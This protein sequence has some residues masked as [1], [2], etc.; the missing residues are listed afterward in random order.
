M[1]IDQIFEKTINDLKQEKRPLHPFSPEDHQ[2]LKAYW[3]EQL[4]QQ[5]L[6]EINKVLCLLEHSQTY[7]SECDELFI[8]SLKE[9]QDTQTLVFLLSASAKHIV[10]RSQR[11]GQRIAF[12]FIEALKELLSHQD[13]E[14]LEWVL[15][16]IDQLGNQALILRPEIIKQKP[17]LLSVF[18]KHKKNSRMIIEMLEKRWSIFS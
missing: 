14:V 10:T 3:H 18:N 11:D 7:S 4:A 16:V 2:E 5:N 15:R 6:K 9:I 8:R 1:N 13:P 17:S 12:A